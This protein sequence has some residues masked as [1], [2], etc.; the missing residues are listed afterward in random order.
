M[1]SYDVTIRMKPTWQYFHVVLIIKLYTMFLNT[2]SAHEILKC[3]HSNESYWAVLSCGTVY[4]AVKNVSK[5]MVK[6]ETYLATLLQNKLTTDAARF[7]THIK[8]V[9][10]QIMLLTGLMWVVEG[11]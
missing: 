2:E 7:T 1:K 6:Q 3:D 5:G 10:Q 11:A 4:Y 9:L 8:P